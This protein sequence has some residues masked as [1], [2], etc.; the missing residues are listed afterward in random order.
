VGEVF[1]I[2]DAT[3]LTNKKLLVVDDV[4]TTGAT[5]E[6]LCKVILAEVP[7]TIAVAAIATPQD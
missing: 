1:R 5:I 4:I 3:A 2:T 6:G 7:C